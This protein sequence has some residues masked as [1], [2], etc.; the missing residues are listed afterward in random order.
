MANTKDAYQKW[1]ESGVLE[2]KLKLIVD[3]YSYKE[4]RGLIYNLLGISEST[5]ERLKKKYADIKFAI[6][7]AKKLHEQLLLVSITRRAEGEYYEDTQTI[8]EETAGKTKKK[9]VKFKKYLPP[10][11]GA[12]K[13]LLSRLHGEKYNE[14]KEMLDIARKRQEN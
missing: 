13:Y 2:S 11:V 12:N 10:D 8:I 5:W 4:A 1:K 3:Y 14:N 9:I 7:E 6:E